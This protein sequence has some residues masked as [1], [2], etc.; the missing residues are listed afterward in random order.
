MYA[1]N[2]V[3][4]VCMRRF[5]CRWRRR[6]RRRRRRWRHSQFTFY[7]I[8]ISRWSVCMCM[9]D[10][11]Y[12]EFSTTPLFFP[13]NCTRHRGHGTYYLL[14]GARIAVGCV[15]LFINQSVK[16]RTAREDTKKV[17]AE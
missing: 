17:R 9:G 7:L 6:R 2:V 11:V 13:Q 3:D 15:V 8:E 4:S 1:R 10:D 12:D 5:H 14:V 16:T